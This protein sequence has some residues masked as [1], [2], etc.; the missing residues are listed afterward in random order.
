MGDGVPD[1]SALEDLTAGTPDLSQLARPE[2]PDPKGIRPPFD[3]KRMTEQVVWIQTWLAIER[4]K[5]PKK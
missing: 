5:N 1:M 2:P 4:K 3:L